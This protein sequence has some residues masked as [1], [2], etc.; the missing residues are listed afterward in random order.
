VTS[1]ELR[2]L[3]A[4]LAMLLAE[5]D[6][7]EIGEALEPCSVAAVFV[8]ENSSAGPLASSIRRAGSR[9][10]AN[11]GIPTQ[12]RLAPSKTTTK[13]TRKEPDMPLAGGR[14]GRRGVIGGSVRRT[15]AVVGTAAVVTQGH[16]R[17]DRRADR[18]DRRE[19]RERTAGR[20]CSVSR[21]HCAR[22]SVGV[23]HEIGRRF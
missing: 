13:T 20:G 17:R 3:E 23:S 11:G 22:R 15:A 5:E 12:P 19:D 16:D 10:V 8:Y 1:C 9:L 2:A 7:E 18:G 21:P 14:P 6:V 4:D